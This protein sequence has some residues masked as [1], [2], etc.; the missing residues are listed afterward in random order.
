MKRR[1]LAVLL[2]GVF[3]SAGLA[4]DAQ[5]S[6]DSGKLD[7]L[8][9]SLRKAIAEQRAA[10]K[11]RRPLS[12]RRG[13]YDVRDLVYPLADRRMPRMDLIPSGGRRFEFRLEEE[14][15]PLPFYEGDQLVDLI[16]DTVAPASWE[17]L[18]GASIRYDEGILLVRQVPEV[19][20]RISELLGDLR[21]RAGSRLNLS[22]RLLSVGDGVLRGIL[23]DAGTGALPAEAEARLER[24]L[25]EG[26]AKILR[27]GSV[28]CTNT[29][30]VVLEDTTVRSYLQDYDV[31]I[32]QEATIA[33]P[34]FQV[35]PEGILAEL[36]PTLAGKG[37][38]V[39]LEVRVVSGRF[40]EPL[41]S[42]TTP[43]GDIETPVLDLEK[44]ETTLVAAPG[45]TVVVGG[46]TSDSG[47]GGWL[48]L[49]TPEVVRPTGK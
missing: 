9:R 34:I 40:R 32:A 42:L 22:V 19:H 6:P 35:V 20:R 30:R 48:L 36:R 24:A 2:L 38:L 31:E 7:D 12:F 17:E 39:V 10:G 37:D 11:G 41:A 28:V 47:E 18:T 43:L 26:R 4:L 29:Q 33:D 13:L 44:V 16:R 14:S 46:V 49:V 45:R 1:F 3:L 23:G 27:R 5:E 21:R 25:A 8:I 15:E